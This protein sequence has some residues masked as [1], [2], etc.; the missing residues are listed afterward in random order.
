ML[1]RPSPAHLQSPGLQED[2]V[3]LYNLPALNSVSFVCETKRDGS[4]Q[5][6]LSACCGGVASMLLIQYLE[7]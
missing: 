3:T 7:I 5:A 2:G 4:L 1:G 6:T